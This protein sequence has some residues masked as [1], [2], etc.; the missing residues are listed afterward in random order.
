MKEPRDKQSGTENERADA[1]RKHEALS[2]RRL[3]AKQTKNAGPRAQ[4]RHTEQGREQPDF[5]VDPKQ[6]L[7]DRVGLVHH[8]PENRRSQHRNEQHDGGA[9][10]DQNRNDRRRSTQ[11][12]RH[13]RGTLLQPVRVITGFI[14][15][16][17]RQVPGVEVT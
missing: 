16:R 4:R 3:G 14:T 15:G 8:L 7:L 11:S 17:L 13:A 10:P 1:N 9:T 5:R 2:Q 12:G 6:P